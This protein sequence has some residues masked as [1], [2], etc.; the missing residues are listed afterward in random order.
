MCHPSDLEFPPEDDPL[1]QRNN[2]DPYPASFFLHLFLPALSPSSPP[3]TPF[4][5]SLTKPVNIIPSGLLKQWPR[6]KHFLK[7]VN[8][9]KVTHFVNAQGQLEVTDLVPAT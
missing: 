2:P 1:C 8:E 7:V 4:S 5:L 3:P 9:V 6:H